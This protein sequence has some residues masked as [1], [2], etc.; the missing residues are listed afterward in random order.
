MDERL[1]LDKILNFKMYIYRINGIL[2]DLLYYLEN[3][4]ELNS[5]LQ[6]E[7]KER[8][9][10]IAGSIEKN[11]KNYNIVI[12]N[13][14]FYLIDVLNY[15]RDTYL[16]LGM[17]T[18]G[19]YNDLRH[20]PIKSLISQVLDS[21]NDI[22]KTSSEAQ[23]KSLQY[24][25]NNYELPNT[26]M[27]N[28][29]VQKAR[30]GLALLSSI[31]SIT[32]IDTKIVFQLIRDLS[33]TMKY[34]VDQ[35]FGNFQ[36]EIKDKD[37]NSEVVD[38]VIS[39]LYNE[40]NSILL[41]NNAINIEDTTDEYKLPYNKPMKL[42]H[43]VNL[44]ISMLEKV[45]SNNLSFDIKLKNLN[46]T[47]PRDGSYTNEAKLLPVLRCGDCGNF[48]E[49]TSKI[50]ALMEKEEYPMQYCHGKLMIWSIIDSAKIKLFSKQKEVYGKLKQAIEFS[51]SYKLLDK[52]EAMKI[53]EFLL[54][55]K[56]DI[57]TRI[58]AHLGMCQLHLYEFKA[59]DNSQALDYIN[60]KLQ[61]LRELSAEYDIKQLFI[62]TNLIDCRIKLI[63]GKFTELNEILHETL[64]Y[65][66][67]NK[68]ENYR[69]K[70]ENELKM[71]NSYLEKSIEIVDSNEKLKNQIF[72]ENIDSYI[73]DVKTLLMDDFLD[74]N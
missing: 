41:R 29:T 14:S 45:E 26:D 57:T 25:K 49:I 68:L 64:A 53:Y 32:D 11:K 13:K 5:T 55:E 43:R 60:Q 36:L 10:I 15:I 22:T 20:I 38:L 72:Q 27:I 3:P 30:Q 1:H 63:E 50:N 19:L 48:I 61:I 71:M 54:Q 21:L 52:A 17:K 34:F 2:Y 35:R 33:T 23:L 16:N 59:S 70:V 66:T 44:L 40:I 4:D 51:K 56:F 28:F 37:G 46:P 18:S 47:S 39:E 9:T 12:R 6:D 69:E 62:E 58:Q 24:I 74:L 31:Q 7:L 65:V 42:I 73:N 8:I 67:L